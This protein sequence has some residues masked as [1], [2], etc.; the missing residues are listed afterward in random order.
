MINWFNL[1]MLYLLGCVHHL[2]CPLPANESLVAVVCIMSQLGTA[3]F[4]LPVYERPLKGI[5]H[6]NMK[7]QS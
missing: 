2:I 5:V 6:S 1:I 7:I 3:H 4:D